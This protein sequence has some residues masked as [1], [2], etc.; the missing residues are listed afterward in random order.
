MSFFGDMGFEAFNQ[1]L[2]V[3]EDGHAIFFN[4]LDAQ[5]IQGFAMLSAL[6]QT[7]SQSDEMTLVEANME[8]LTGQ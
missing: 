6:Q 1:G 8:H 7:I 5:L 3:P 2:H 4:S